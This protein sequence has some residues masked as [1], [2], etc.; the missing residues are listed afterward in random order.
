MSVISHSLDGYRDEFLKT[1]FALDDNKEES[2]KRS[3]WWDKAQK[4][5]PI[6]LEKTNAFFMAAAFVMV[7][8]KISK[9]NLYKVLQS[10]VAKYLSS[11][12]DIVGTM[13]TSSVMI[14]TT[15][16]KVIVDLLRYYETV[17]HS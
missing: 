12:K 11:S 6:G 5:F 1:T 15:G 16:N 10:M 3:E 17:L 8:M 9:N 4:M 14:S 13:S 2:D 7:D